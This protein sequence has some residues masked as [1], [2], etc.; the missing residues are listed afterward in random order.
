MNN[1]QYIEGRRTVSSQQRCIYKLIQKIR[2][3][4]FTNVYINILNIFHGKSFVQLK[5]IIIEILVS[6]LLIS[7]IKII[8]IF[9]SYGVYIYF[10]Y[11]LV[12]YVKLKNEKNNLLFFFQVF[13]C[14]WI[15][16][17]IYQLLNQCPNGAEVCTT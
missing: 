16:L 10:D 8:G 2:F 13:S 11:V 6:M 14:L 4:F 17:K 7:K 5:K 15:H 9:L 3:Y 1:I 12:Y